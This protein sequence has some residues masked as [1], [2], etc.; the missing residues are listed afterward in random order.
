VRNDRHGREPSR[1]LLGKLVLVACGI[2]L[3][4]AG[5]AFANGQPARPGAPTTADPR[6]LAPQQ[7]NTGTSDGVRLRARDLT[8]RDLAYPGTAIVDNGTIQLGVNA[9][10]DLNVPGGTPSSGEHTQY[11][12]LRFMPTNADA[13]SPGCLCE[14]WGVGDA[15][16]PG[17]TDPNAGDAG[18]A[19]EDRG[20]AE[21]L[22][23]VDFSATDHTVHSVV[24]VLGGPHQD[25][26]IMRVTHDYVPSPATPNLYEADV[27]V[28]N[29]TGSPIGDLRYRRVMDWD[30]E[31]TAF[32]EY[33]TID[34]DPTTRDLVY[35][36]DDGFATADPLYPPTKIDAA[37]FF[38]DNGPDDHGA[39]FD[40]SFGTLGPLETERFK[41]Y[42]G[43]APT[44]AAA[45]A[46]ISAVQAEVWSFGQPSTPDGPTLGT[47]NTF[48]FGFG[49]VGGAGSVDDARPPVTLST[50]A[51]NRLGIGA[52]DFDVAAQLINTSDNDISGGRV[53]IAP[54]ADLTLMS[55]A[56]PAA[57]GTLPRHS[58]DPQ[59]GSRWSLRVPA[60]E[61]HASH[62]YGYDVFGDFDGSA[63]SGGERHVHRTILVPRTCGQIAGTVTFEHAAGETLDTGPVA[64]A[65]I[66]ACP[67]AGGPCTTATSGGDGTY[68]LDDLAAGTYELEAH[69]PVDDARV[70]DLAPIAQE[71]TLEAGASL[72]QDFQFSDL[73][74]PPADGSSTIRSD[75]PETTD[76]GLPMVYWSSPLH[77]VTHVTACTHPTVT[78]AITQ[79]DPIVHTIASGPMS[80]GP[81]GTFTGDTPAVY[82][83]HGYAL[84]TFTV[85]CADPSKNPA[86]V[87]FDIYIDP[88]GVVRGVDGAPLAGAKV[89]LLRATS[90]GGPFTA[91]PDGSA[92]M[93]PANR[94]NPDA[95]DAA[96]HFGWDVTPGFY[97][98]RAEKD[99]CR[100][101]AD[102]SVPYAQTDVLQV[103]P[104]ALGLVLTLDCRPLLTTSSS[105]SSS[106]RPPARPTATLR[107]PG[108]RLRSARLKGRKLTVRG[109]IAA[110]LP[111]TIRLVYKPRHGHRTR[112]LRRTVRPKHGRFVVTLRLPR[113]ARPVSL[114]VS[115]S[116][117]SS[118]KAGRV[119][120]RF[121]H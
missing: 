70:K 51:P 97:R 12:G 107:A 86:P 13:T 67:Q 22:H 93:A 42:Y 104:P 4:L 109:T 83:N 80:E 100:S 3:L 115:S 41:I 30:V 62:S 76:D 21:Q 110:P 34:G 120:Q 113:G 82:P 23:V 88:S 15:P 116:A 18:F 49:G 78:Y 87:A 58:T 85:R 19:N 28:E 29:L 31:P 53:R 77:L 37:G 63:G 1:L 121:R 94:T 114:T 32:N 11:V 61:C 98:V 117:T 95:T 50:Q 99:G 102:A 16:V 27:S 64:G 54:G 55:G 71:L 45:I 5:I 40:F 118:F 108:L 43:A 89:T 112:V 20:G 25:T 36:T 75:V 17:V 84:V 59:P 92:V 79:G 35:S 72:G 74:K 2:L 7:A 6:N 14:G 81:A 119:T 57:V 47:P 8:A 106:T 66:V 10:G 69:P 73:R 60:P 111:V 44:E 105:G 24:D 90:A 38:R 52:R 9:A 101:P 68:K 65:A 103:P 33:V 96:G 26:P 46:A 48:V 91:V 39:L 56:N